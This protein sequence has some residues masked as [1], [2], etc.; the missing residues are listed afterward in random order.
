MTIFLLNLG[1][2]TVYIYIYI[3]FTLDVKPGSCELE[4]AAKDAKVRDTGFFQIDSCF[5]AGF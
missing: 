4:V 2:F 3:I 5:Q 1:H